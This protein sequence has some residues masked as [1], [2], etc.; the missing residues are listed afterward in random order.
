M[1]KFNFALFALLIAA[2]A[3]APWGEVEAKRLGGGRSFGGRP[4]YSYPYQRSLLPPQRATAPVK[5]AATPQTARQPL[6]NRSSPL[7]WLAPF[8]A[9]GLLGWLLGSG[10]FQH[11]NLV[12]LLVFGG[13]ALALVKLLA[14]RRQP[15]EAAYPAGATSSA[16]EG[17]AS[18]AFDTDL[19]FKR[20]H[21]KPPVASSLVHTPVDFDLNDF[22]DQAKAIFRKL[23]AAWS[24]GELA[25]IR[26]LTTDEAFMEIKAQKECGE[27]GAV[28]VLALEAQLLDY[29][30]TADA[31]MAAVLFAATLAEEGQEPEPIEEIWHFVRAKNAVRPIWRLDGI[32]QIEG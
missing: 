9:G 10:S 19:L 6:P 23:Q 15:E 20:E 27:S 24:Q 11:L 14:R 32:Q 21:L 28:E 22:L 16:A 18:R 25:E 26:A 30:E 13:I 1:S 2:L 4:S 12:D 3:A 8:L 17:S 29:Q 31:Q 5:A 7:G